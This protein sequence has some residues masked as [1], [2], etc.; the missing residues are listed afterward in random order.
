M[1]YLITGLGN[2][3]SQYW[4]TRHNIGFRVVNKLV[5]DSGHFFSEE[6]YGAV[7]RMRVKNKE[8]VVLKPNTFMNLSGNAV[9]YWLQ[10]ENIPVENLLVIVDD[11]ALPFGVLRLKPK[12]SD[13]GHNG[14]KNI[15]QILGTQE[16]TRL[17]FGVGDYFPRGGQVEYVLGQ[18]DPEELAVMPEKVD[19]AVEIIKSF[20]LSGIQFTMNQYNNKD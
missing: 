14:L 8:L 4:G 15:Q 1:K 11:I 9:R 10:K 17:R 16:Y 7:A 2:I 20:C 12:G 3:G 18:F 6:R 19:R 13:A 5:E